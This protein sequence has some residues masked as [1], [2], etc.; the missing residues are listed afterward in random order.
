[1]DRPL[2]E[3]GL[4]SLAAV[5]IQQAVDAALGVSLSVAHLLAGPTLTDLAKEIAQALDEP[6]ADR[7]GL[8]MPKEDELAAFP[9]TQGQRALWFLDRR[10]SK[11]SST[12]RLCAAP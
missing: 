9:L 3:L 6:V 12:A 10:E 11:A 2:T 5:E 1:V 4:D 7:D 8:A